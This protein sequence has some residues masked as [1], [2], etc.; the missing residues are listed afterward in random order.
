MR[1]A[2]P[3][4]VAAFL[5]T[6]A[7]AE[8]VADLTAGPAEKVATGFKFTEGPAHH[9]G[10][11]L[12]FSDIPNNRI[13]KL[14]YATGETSTFADDT[15][16]NNGIVITEGGTIVGCRK[17]PGVAVYDADGSFQLIA[18]EFEGKP[19]NSPNDLSLDAA[20]G[21]YFTDP[22]YGKR[23]QP[24]PVQGVYYISADGGLSRV[25]DDVPRPNGVNV[26]LD[27]KTLY[28]ADADNSRVLA[29][30]IVA[31]GK[32]DNRRVF[33]AGDPDADGHGPDGMCFDS[34]GRLYATMAQTVVISPD[35]ERIGVIETPE[36]P[37]NC[38]FGGPDNKTL[39]I[40]ARTSLYAVPM[41]VTGAPA[42]KTG[43]QVGAAAGAAT[44]FVQTEAGGTK[45]VELRELKLEIPEGWRQQQS[46]SR[47]R[48]GTWVVPAAEGDTIPVEYVVYTPMGGGPKANIER[49]IKQFQSDG[50]EAKV[51]SGEAGDVNYVLADITGTY[52]MSIGP[53]MMGK[54]QPVPD[55]R[56]LAVVLS[57]PS[58][59]DYFI[60]MAGPK[61]TVDAAAEA[62]RA[63]FGADASKE[64]E[65]EM[66]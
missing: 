12:L 49:W 48:M 21:V 29:Y 64:A 63:S 5:T 38:T 66:D 3:A 7:F 62:F 9:A 61:K 42:P 47:M 14:D 28:V 46:A 50:R 41:K 59:G 13:V 11:F 6:A 39:Y 36:K 57:A 52:N 27:G 19:L 20:G 15:E 17:T 45:S 18:S 33:F 23:D 43:P 34:D 32:L 25:I 56:M 55:A 40:T 1:H 35:G 31:P 8:D 58:G 65:F 30:D 24:Q 44:Y 60:K 16:G 54:T 26:S 22:V 2:L 51:T 53:P 4:L 10:G 37:A